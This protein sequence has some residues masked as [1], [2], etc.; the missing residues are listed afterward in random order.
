MGEKL[1]SIYVLCNYG[2]SLSIA[3]KLYSLNITPHD[4]KVN[5][6]CLDTILGKD[7]LK[8]RKVISCLEKMKNTEGDESIYILLEFGLSLNI[9]EKLIENDI[10]FKDL[11]KE[12]FSNKL[13]NVY[14]FTNSTTKK[15]YKAFHEYKENSEIV[16]RLDYSKEILKILKQQKKEYIKIDK[17]KEDGEFRELELN[18]E[19]LIENLKQLE[20]R[21]EIFV[22]NGIIKIH[23]ETLNNAIKKIK[24]AIW[25][26]ILT[27]SFKGESYANIG[28]SK[29]LSRERVRQIVNKALA[30]IPFVREDLY[31][32]IFKEYYWEV[33][34]FCDIFNEDELSY[35]YLKS[36][37][38]I[39]TKD[40]YELLELDILNEEQKNKLKNHLNLIT[41]NNEIFS[42]NRIQLL[43][44]IITTENRLLNVEEIIEIYNKLVQNDYKDTKLEIV[45]QESFRNVEAMLSR[46]DKVVATYNR[47]YRYYNFN[48][49]TESDKNNLKNML[50]VKNGIY[51]AEYF[52]ENN[53][54]LMDSLD[55]QNKYELHNI[56]RRIILEDEKIQFGRMPDILIGEKDKSEFLIKLIN[57]L[58][59]ITVDEF[60]KVL[61]E[62]YGHDEKTM[63]AYVYNYLGAF[64]TNNILNTKV[65][66]FNE[67]QLKELDEMLIRDIYS[68]SEIEGFVKKIVGNTYTQYLNN[69]NFNRVGYKVR[70]QYIYRISINSVDSFI[71]NKILDNDIYEENIEL[72]S[73][74]TSYSW[75][76]GDLLLKN[77]IYKIA[78]KKYITRKGL[79]KYGIDKI[80]IDEF[81]RKI[82]NSFEDGDI[83]NIY[84]LESK[85]LINDKDYLGFD[86]VF[87][88]SLFQY[89][90]SLKII[91]IEN[92]NLFVKSKTSYTKS[93]FIS[94]IIEKNFPLKSE[95]ICEILKK[96]YGVEIDKYEVRYLMDKKKYVRNLEDDF[97]T[98]RGV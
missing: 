18:T 71:R 19:E 59:P 6:S 61:K 55:I 93:D 60:A 33:D 67:K 5:K 90:S 40:V 86:S 2:L 57:I 39:G 92:N 4:I 30:S 38:D 12:E 72:S 15:I 89:T 43:E 13:M 32:N 42:A 91:R 21:K 96:Q 44:A 80:K 9:I 95:R 25:I 47:K 49:L 87:I 17:L 82:V 70:E 50:E 1:M 37:Y 74:G 27:R 53:N 22:E 14:K 68:I 7:S 64:I 26:E 81:V 77:E 45:D 34:I 76:V 66:E 84:M 52:Y 62:N 16:K 85:N 3:K 46:S 58:S 79:K 24:K 48:L 63:Y 56:L 41:Y 65:E 94:Y 88:E 97:I 51:S 78:E 28:N 54:Q 10:V 75:V 35:G 29:G 11:E 73:A 83:F 31:A 69:L 98:K 23:Y 36:K 8:S 20:K